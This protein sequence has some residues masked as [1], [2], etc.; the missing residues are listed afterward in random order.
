MAR[1]R[2]PGG[3]RPS[4][5]VAAALGPGTSSTRVAQHITVPS[6]TVRGRVVVA[7][8]AAGAFVAAG[9]TIDHTAVTISNDPTLL[10][11]AQDVS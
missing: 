4:L 10:A 3:P 8:V 5:V 11:S 1:H 6:P 9:Q 2:S 7:A